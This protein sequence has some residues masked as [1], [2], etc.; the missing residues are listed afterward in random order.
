MLRLIIIS[1][2]L[3]NI[4][5]LR[6]ER[7]QLIIVLTLLTVKRFYIVLSSPY[8]GGEEVKMKS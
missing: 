5:K 7:S 1:W 4:V 6:Y 2:Y 3:S 8:Q